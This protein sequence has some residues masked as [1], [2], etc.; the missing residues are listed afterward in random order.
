MR[1]HIILAVAATAMALASCSED[2]F[3][4]EGTITEAEDSV[5]YFEHVGID[6]LERLDSARLGADGGF[7]FSARRIRG[8]R[9]PLKT[10]W[11]M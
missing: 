7:S 10:A 11:R 1:H 9:R 5:L 8:R 3:R 4:I 2:K 6:G